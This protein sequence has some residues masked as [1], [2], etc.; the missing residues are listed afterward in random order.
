M[1]TVSINVPFQGFYDSWYSNA[2]DREEEEFV[3]YEVN[4]N[5]DGERQH[6]EE[7]RLTEYELGD[8]LSSHTKYSTAYE[9]VARNY[10]DAFARYVADEL[11]LEFT[12]EFE[13][14]TSPRYYNFET[15]RLFARVPF[16]TMARLFAMSKAEGHETLGTTIR[17]RFT[18]YDGFISHY[19]NTLETWASKPLRD[20]DHN[21]LCTLLLACLKIKG[22]EGYEWPVF[23][24]L[25]DSGFY[26]EWSEAVDWQAFE[27]ARED[28]RLEK[29]A[30]FKEENG[31]DAPD[32]WHYF[33]RDPRQMSL[34][35]FLGRA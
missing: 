31:E 32:Q 1:K 2:I 18:S 17:D 25:A 33:S 3:D 19:D 30:Q 9:T 4:E 16:K 22:A 15:D 5:E 24:A 14:M 34:P 6:P 26:G 27:S 35:L 28:L 20:W 21:E 7:I 29:L 13:E 12:L 23:D 8:L 10:V 11:G